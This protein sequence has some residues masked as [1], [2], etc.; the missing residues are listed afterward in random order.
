M[1]FTPKPSYAVQMWFGIL[2]VVLTAL[3]LETRHP[4]D[5]GS[6][7]L[8]NSNPDGVGAEVI[9]DG[10]KLGTVGDAKKSGLGGGAFWAHLTRG[11]H[12]VE[13]R[14]PGYVP[15]SKELEMHGEAYLGVDL[16]PQNN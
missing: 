12:I 13:L 6:N 11:K 7:F 1:S 3:F 8:I 15:Y 4:S 2:V 9:V 5:S 16:T 10:Q 14:K